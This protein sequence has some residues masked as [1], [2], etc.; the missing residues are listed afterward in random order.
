ME[1]S[2]FNLV[3]VV[4]VI[5]FAEFMQSYGTL[6]FDNSLII[7]EWCNKFFQKCTSIKF[8]LSN[9][10]AANFAL[11]C[12]LLTFSFIAQYPPSSNRPQWKFLWI[13]AIVIQA[14]NIYDHGKCLLQSEA[15][16][17]LCSADCLITNSKYR[18]NGH[19]NMGQRHV[20]NWFQTI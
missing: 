4:V 15:M 6:K 10:V 2:S 14:N 8:I 19:S 18:V 17:G 9:T 3:F 5:Y 20:V 12:C 7:F 11:C 16:V 13:S 1:G